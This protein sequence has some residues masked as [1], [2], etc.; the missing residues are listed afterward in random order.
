M[1][2]QEISQMHRK[3]PHDA[4]KKFT[5]AFKKI[6]RALEDHFYNTNMRQQIYD[7]ACI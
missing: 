2:I 4:F 6:T 7:H 1:C 3:S 5:C